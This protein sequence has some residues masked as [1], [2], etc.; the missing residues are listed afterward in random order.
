MY[1]KYDK[2]TYPANS[3]DSWILHHFEVDVCEM[4]CK[5]HVSDLVLIQVR[6]G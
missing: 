4:F 5:V 3:K 1:T 6:R 2:N